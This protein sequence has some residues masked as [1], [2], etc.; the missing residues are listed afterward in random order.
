MAAQ[1]SLIDKKTGLPQI[2]SEFCGL[3][4]WGRGQEGQLG[5]GTHQANSVP[6]MV[7]A[8]KGRRVLQVGFLSL[9][10]ARLYWCLWVSEI[11]LSVSLYFL[12]YGIYLQLVGTA[13]RSSMQVK[14]CNEPNVV[15]QPIK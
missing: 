7:E 9:C 3:F 13:C 11:K 14:I 6:K 5:V 12:L 1:G 15:R 4:M 10:L 8:L 2:G